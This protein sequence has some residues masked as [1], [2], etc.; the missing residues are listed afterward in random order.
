MNIDCYLSLTCASE[1]ALRE[2]IDQALEQ[3]AVEAPVN[4]YRLSDSE[5]ASRGFKGSPTVL[6]D[7][8]VVQPVELEGFS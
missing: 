1:E 5:A 4:F 2:N 8:E 7:G 6:I 3:E